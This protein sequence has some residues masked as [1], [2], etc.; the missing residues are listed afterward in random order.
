MGMKVLILVAATA[1]LP[2]IGSQFLL[3]TRVE[4]QVRNGEQ[5]DAIPVQRLKIRACCR[6]AL[7]HLTTLYAGGEEHGGVSRG[8]LFDDAKGRYYVRNM[9]SMEKFLVFDSAGRYLHA[10]G[11]KGD[12]PGEFQNILDAFM[13]AD[14][15]IH[16]F[17]QAQRTYTILN[18]DYTYSTRYNMG[19]RL[20]QPTLLT[21]GLLVVNAT[22]ATGDGFGHPLH[23]IENG[24]V[25]PIGG[26]VLRGKPR[27]DVADMRMAIARAS[28]STFW[29]AHG[30]SYTIDLI[31]AN[32]GK[33]LRRLV[34][35]PPW[36]NLAPRNTPE[37]MLNPRIVQLM[38]D[39]EGRLWVHSR[40]RAP[41]WEKM[42]TE[43]RPPTD[44]AAFI[45]VKPGYRPGQMSNSIVE[46]IDT[47]TATLLVSSR[48][49]WRF[50]GFLSPGKV[51]IYD[52]DADGRGRLSIWRV[53][54]SPSPGS[55]TR[56]PTAAV[57]TVVSAHAENGGNGNER[58]RRMAGRLWLL[59]G[60]LV[61]PFPPF[62]A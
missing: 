50:R 44:R 8:V 39:A 59:L 20:S 12:G 6:P 33:V 47:N 34:R 14:G 7:T 28:D 2:L 32:T 15:K 60:G 48:Y 55:R 13:A 5:Q 3:A 1:A 18:P 10:F 27:P 26:D 45:T 53:S 57:Q 37:G 35:E 42:Y 30:Q 24:E 62:S 16:V 41:G 58:V 49:D 46:V 43:V 51:S 23:L 38:V 25:R 56:R 61:V 17:D 52:E 11:K 31:S 22:T 36:F 9:F 29:A 40:V 21:D 4:A 19:I 54:L